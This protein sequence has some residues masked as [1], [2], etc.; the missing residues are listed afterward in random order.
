MTTDSNTSQDFPELRRPE[1]GQALRYK[2]EVDLAHNNTSQTHVVMLTGWGKKVLEVGPATGYVTKVLKERGCRV[3]GVEIDPAAAKIAEQF[4]ERIIVGNIERLDLPSVF[5]GERFDVVLFADVLEHLVDPARVLREVRSILAPGGYVCASIPN[6]AH[7]SIRL[8]LLAGDFRYTE[9]GLLDR[10]HLRFFNFDGVNELFAGSGYVVR[11]WERVEV[12]VFSTEL[13]L[14][15]QDYPNKLIEAV[16]ASPEYL[17]YQFVVRAEPEPDAALIQHSLPAPVNGDGS[18]IKRVFAPLW[19]LELRAWELQQQVHGLEGQLEL[20]RSQT[21]AAMSHLQARLAGVQHRYDEV[22]QRTNYQLWQKFVGVL[23]RWAPWGTRRRRLILMPGYAFRI[24]LEKGPMG[25][26]MHLLKF[27]HWVPGL[28]RKA[29]HPSAA[30]VEDRYKVWEELYMLSPELMRAMRRQ[31]KHFAYRPEVSII[32]PVHD[33]EPDW[34]REAIESVRGQIYS[35]WELC[36]ADDGSTRQDVLEMLRQYEQTDARIKVSYLEQNQGIVAASSAALELATGDFVGLLDHDDELKPNALYQVVKLLNERSD[37]DYIYT[38]LD[39]KT[40]EGRLVDPFLKPDW[41]PDFLLSCNY[42]THFSV[43]RKDILD[44]VGGFHEGYDG[45]QDWDLV[46]RVTETTDRIGHVRVPLYTWR[47]VPGSAA[48]SGG[49][50]PWAHEAAKRAIADSL[51]RRGCNA[52]VEDGPYLGYY[53]VRYEIVGNPKVIIIIP[54]R[55]RL[56]LLRKCIDSI[57][58]RTTWKNY[59]IVVVDNDSRDEQTLQYLESFGGRVVSYPGEFNFS[60]IINAAAP[61]GADGDYL[62]LLNNDTEVISA[63]WIQA[64]LEHAQ[65]SEV[66]AVGARLLYPDGKAQ[67]EGVIVGPGD[68]LAGNIDF[69]NYFGL[70]RCI[71]NPSAVTAACMMT[72]VQVFRELG[73]FEEELKVAY[74]DV[75]YCLRAGE[76]GYLIVYTPYATLN[77]DEAAT[78]GHGDDTGKAHPVEDE[79]FFRRRWAGYRDPF[80]PPS[81]KPHLPNVPTI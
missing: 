78:R 40:P 24:L 68:G 16:S 18:Q 8:S 39:H 33:P 2:T 72:R 76:K 42:V 3:T 19:G 73:G 4:C 26:A 14:R 74:N 56:D 51:A 13:G 60:K 67:H 62:L 59:E 53:R 7:G 71:H 30:P 57:R 22:V 27:W 21:D 28:F 81:W 69:D 63:E 29:M 37:L 44:K 43:F 45:S 54:T 64:M 20:E 65:R 31:V 23:D 38:D 17:T 48:R 11:A 55:D 35:K 1:E 79:E 52:V 6:I 70:G 58:Q 9:V 46:L 36:I 25:L 15:P 41:S 34:L 77:H 75:D 5:S 50:K 10:T 32:M 49:A 61:E 47:Q 80:D 66:A 12:D